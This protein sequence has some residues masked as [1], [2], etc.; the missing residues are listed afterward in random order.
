VELDEAERIANGILGIANQN[1]VVKQQELGSRLNTEASALSLSYI[2]PM[3]NARVVR[4]TQE[5]D[6]IY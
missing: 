6:S 3:K 1:S 5:V 4:A 2:N